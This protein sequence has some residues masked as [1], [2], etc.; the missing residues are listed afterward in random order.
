MKIGFALALV[1][2]FAQGQGPAPTCNMCPGTY[3]PNSEIQ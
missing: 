2:L 3:I 1:M